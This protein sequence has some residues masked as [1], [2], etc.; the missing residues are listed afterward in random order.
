MAHLTVPLPVYRSA[1]LPLR[2]S[3]FMTIILFWSMT[4]SGLI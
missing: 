1:I 3:K 2:Y 4:D